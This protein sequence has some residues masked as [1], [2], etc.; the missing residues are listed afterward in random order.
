MKLILKS[1]Q[2]D[3][4]DLQYQE[5]FK[6]TFLSN[7]VLM[8]QPVGVSRLAKLKA[9]DNMWVAGPCSLH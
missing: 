5:L 4:L 9:T 3:I 7:T 2:E 8:D 6:E 1:F